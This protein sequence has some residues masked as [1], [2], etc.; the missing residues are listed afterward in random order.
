MCAWI[1]DPWNRGKFRDQS[2]TTEFARRAVPR[3]TVSKR[4]LYREQAIR[5]S[6]NHRVT[7]ARNLFQSWPVQDGDLAAVVLYQ[8]KLL[9]FSC[10]IGDA[11]SPDAEHIGNQLL[12]HDQLI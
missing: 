5:F 11:F 7:L 1:A 2:S 10:R 8:P 4:R 3:R 12:S 9:Q 6:L